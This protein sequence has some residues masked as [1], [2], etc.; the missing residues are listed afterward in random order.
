MKKKTTSPKITSFRWGHVETAEGK[1]YKDVKL[2]PGGSEN[3]D[4]NETGT[5]HVPG[6]Q[7]ADLQTLLDH[8]CEI[9]ILSKGVNKRLQTC[10]ETVRLLEE[11]N[12]DYKIL[13][14]EEAINLYNQLAESRKVGALVHSTC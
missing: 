9:I 6:I 2:Y 14:T 3:W 12:I 8:N 4:W 5:R 10:E 1:T 13:Q 11:R 7:P